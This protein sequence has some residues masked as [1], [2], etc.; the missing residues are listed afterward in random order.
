ML[1]MDQVMWQSL[2]WLLQTTS[3][4]IMAKRLLPLHA[5]QQTPNH[6]LLHISWKI[7]RISSLSHPHQL[8]RE[9][10]RQ[11]VFI[12]FVEWMETVRQQCL[13]CSKRKRDSRIAHTLFMRLLALL[14]HCVRETLSHE[15]R[16]QACA[17]KRCSSAC[18]WKCV[19]KNKTH[20]LA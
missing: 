5:R 17:C 10:L 4:S 11:C 13:H 9:Q 18:E 1:S 8:G 7:S 6:S 2:V 14:S 16:M 20:H 12:H 19:R 15:E 3:L